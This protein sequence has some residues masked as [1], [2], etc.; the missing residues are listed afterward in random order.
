MPFKWEAGNWSNEKVTLHLNAMLRG[1]LL[2]NLCKEYELVLTPN[3]GRGQP[4][5]RSFCTRLC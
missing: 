4:K 1:N 2:I 3:T 5:T